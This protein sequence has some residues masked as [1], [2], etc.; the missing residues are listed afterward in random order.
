MNLEE[1]ENSPHFKGDLE[2]LLR[3]GIKYN[4]DV[5]FDWLK[6]ELVAKF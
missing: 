4:Q 6:N 3:S 5:A 1:K 2:A